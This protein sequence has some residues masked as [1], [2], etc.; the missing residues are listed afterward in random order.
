MNKDW[1]DI[2]SAPKDCSEFLGLDQSG[3]EH[4]CHYACD[5]SGGDQPPFK[6]FFESKGTYF[7]EVNIIKWKPLEK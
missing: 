4:I 3:V 1:Q 2:E 6:G 5:M 7:A